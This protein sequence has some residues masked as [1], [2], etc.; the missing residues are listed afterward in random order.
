MQEAFC[1]HPRPLTSWQDAEVQS[2]LFGLLAVPLSAA[3]EWLLQNV[4][5]F[6]MID[7]VI[8]IPKNHAML[9]HPN[10]TPGECL[11]CLDAQDELRSSAPWSH[12]V[13]WWTPTWMMNNPWTLCC[14]L[15]LCQRGQ[16]VWM[17]PLLLW[18]APDKLQSSI[19]SFV[20][21]CGPT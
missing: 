21:V 2:F 6:M 15:L 9:Y 3:S 13:W 14:T 11:C 10:I 12:K 17:E 1:F 5:I 4:R 19:N 16:L 8:F 20:C 18:F 7:D